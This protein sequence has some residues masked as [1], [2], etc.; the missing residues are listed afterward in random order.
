MTNTH[1]E[2]RLRMNTFRCKQQ[3]HKLG[4]KKKRSMGGIVNEHRSNK[5]FSFRQPKISTILRFNDTITS[6]QT[7]KKKYIDI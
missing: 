3:Q 7:N 5:L 2:Y 1:I 4:V 6:V